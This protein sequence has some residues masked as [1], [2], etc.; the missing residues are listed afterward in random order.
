VAIDDEMRRA[1]KELGER[2]RARRVPTQ[3]ETAYSLLRYA[4][5]QDLPAWEY[6]IRE[7]I[8]VGGCLISF[9]ETRDEQFVSK[10]WPLSVVLARMLNPGPK[11][12]PWYISLDTV[13]SESVIVYAKCLEELLGPP[14]KAYGMYIPPQIN[15]DL[16]TS[17]RHGWIDISW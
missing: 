17:P 5:R 3:K 11:T 13:G 14:F 8:A 16:Y 15:S 1:A 9:P 10:S 4:A 7:Q 2:A 12:P 6:R